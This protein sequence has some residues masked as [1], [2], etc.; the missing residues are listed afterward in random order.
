MKVFVTGGNGFIGSVVVRDLVTSGHHVVCL[1]RPTS[2]TER[3]EGLAL[4]RVH[5][6]VCD[7][8]SIR[9]GMRGCASTIHLAAPSEYRR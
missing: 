6:D 2:R 5:G 9:A 4:E 7:L 8:A 3:I 1:L